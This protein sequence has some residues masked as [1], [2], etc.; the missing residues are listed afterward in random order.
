MNVIIEKL[1]GP[2]IMFGDVN[3][4]GFVSISDVTTL[5]DHLLSSDLE[6]SDSFSPDAADIN[7]DGS[8]SI[9]DV[10]ALI[11]KLLAGEFEE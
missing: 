5:I 3:R 1:G 11:D 10:S 8:I 4:D 9:S 2:A 6:E 7:E